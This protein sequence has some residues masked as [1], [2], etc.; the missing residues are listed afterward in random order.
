MTRNCGFYWLETGKLA[1]S[2]YP[3]ECFD[4]LFH[5]QGIRALV[6]LEP[7]RPIDSEK[8]KKLG[9]QIA[10]VPIVDY[11][12]GSPQQRKQALQAIINFMHKGLPVL[13]HCKGGLGRTGMILALYLVS[14]KGQTPKT[15]ISQIRS[16]KKGSIEPNTGQAEAIRAN[17]LEE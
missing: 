16:L 7:L 12:A 2:A 15:A 10:K 17:N 13:V 11:S 9:F 4:W 5:Q 8:A 1:G 6:S 14:Q 3:G